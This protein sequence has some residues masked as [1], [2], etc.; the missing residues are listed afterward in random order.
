MPLRK[1]PIHDATGRPASLLE[2]RQTAHISRLDNGGVPADAS[3]LA[4]FALRLGGPFA[5]GVGARL[6]TLP[7][8]LCLRFGGYSSASRSFAIRLGLFIRLSG[9]IVKYLNWSGR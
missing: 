3:G 2:I 9:W 6:S 1:N 7:G 8:F 4:A 5:A